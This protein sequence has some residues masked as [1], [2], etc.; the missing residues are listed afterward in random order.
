MRMNIQ[1]HS[2]H[3]SGYGRFGFETVKALKALGVEQ[4]GDIGNE[5]SD[6]ELAHEALWLSTPPHVRGWYDGQHATIFTMWESTEIPPGFRENLHNFDRIIVPSLQNKELYERF[7][8]DVRYVPLGVDPN[9]WFPTQRPRVGRDFVFL[10]AGFGP[11]K[12]DRKSVV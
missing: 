11:R 9:V 6:V 5:E 10:T 8:K 4:A 12:G 2:E 7:H 3:N 1:F